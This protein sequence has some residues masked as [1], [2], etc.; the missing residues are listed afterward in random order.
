MNT[1]ALITVVLALLVFT[2]CERAIEKDEISN[3][4]I[5]LSDKYD[6]SQVDP[7]RVKQGRQLYLKNCTVCHGLNAEGAP[8]WHQRDKD[9]KWPPPPLN[10]T[11]H[12]WHHPKKALIYTIKNGT[13]ALGGNM[14]STHGRGDRGYYSMVSVTMAGTVVSGLGT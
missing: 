13:A 2:G 9:G 8:N 12:A 14:P 7:V 11:G 5:R 4:S 3:Q 6:R 1:Y 10:G